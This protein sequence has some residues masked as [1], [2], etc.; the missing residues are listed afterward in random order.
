MAPRMIFVYGPP[1]VGKLTVANLVAERTGFRVLHNHLTI[2]A[3]TPIFDFGSPQFHRL[4]GLFRSELIGAAAEAGVD[5]VAT[6]VYA[7]GDEEIVAGLVAPYADRVTFVQLLA[8]PEELRRRVLGESRR[9]HGK[10]T[11]VELLDAI[12][13]RYDCFPSI[14]GR[15]SLTLDMEQLSAEEAADRI[16][17]AL[18]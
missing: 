2:D 14:P 3:I 4:V 15:E 9:T 1:A 7:T 13:E 11:D 10:I 12:L 6:F 5:V 16:V 18:R 8:G 17:G